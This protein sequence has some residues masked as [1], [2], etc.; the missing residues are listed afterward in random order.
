[1]K[2]IS[3]LLIS[4]SLRIYKIIRNKRCEKMVK[5][6]GYGNITVKPVG[7]ILQLSPI[8]YS[9]MVGMLIDT[10][11]L[12]GGWGLIVTNNNYIHQ[13]SIN[14]NV[15]NIGFSTVIILELITIYVLYNILFNKLVNYI[16]KKNNIYKKENLV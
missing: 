2:G 15:D 8:Y 3:S 4:G 6:K 14:W 5:I 10:A 13:K 9:L 16:S 1:M 7:T 12:I 11:C